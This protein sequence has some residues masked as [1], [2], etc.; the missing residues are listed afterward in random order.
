MTSSR[1]GFVFLL[2]ACSVLC[3]SAQF[4]DWEKTSALPHLLLVVCAVLKQEGSSAEHTA[5]LKHLRKHVTWAK[6]NS[7]SVATPGSSPHAV[8]RSVPSGSLDEETSREIQKPL[9]AAMSH[10]DSLG[11]AGQLVPMLLLGLVAGCASRHGSK[12]AA[13]PRPRRTSPSVPVSLKGSA[14]DTQRLARNS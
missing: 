4:S 1:V 5:F 7:E 10:G 6:E 14:Q 2:S 3:R 12:Q 11:W 9:E 13:T 8:P